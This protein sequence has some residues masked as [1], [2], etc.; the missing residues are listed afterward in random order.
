MPYQVN[1]NLMINTCILI[2]TVKMGS[3]RVGY[4]ATIASIDCSGSM[5]VF[6]FNLCADKSSPNAFSRMANNV[7]V[8]ILCYELRGTITKTASTSITIQQTGLENDGF[9]TQVDELA[10]DLNSSYWNSWRG[11]TIKLSQHCFLVYYVCVR[12]V[13]WM[14]S[15]C[16]ISYRCI[17]HTVLLITS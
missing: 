16:R 1:Y 8:S 4:F 12:S 7:T 2:T 6:G 13:D 5:Y 9:E 15:V 10:L 17:C 3:P 11:K 14:A